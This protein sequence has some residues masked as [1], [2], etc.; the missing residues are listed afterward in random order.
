MNPAFV[1][2]LTQ[3]LGEASPPAR[4]ETVSGGDINAAAIIR[5]ASASYFAKFGGVDREA[6][7]AEAEGLATLRQANTSLV[8]PKPLA[9]G[10]AGGQAFLVLEQLPLTRKSPTTDRALGMG[11]AELHAPAQPR[12]G[13]HR[14][15]RI[16]ATPQPNRWSDDWVVFF[17]RYRLRHQARLLGH[18][19]VSDAVEA[20]A[21]AL[22]RLFAGFE[23]YPSLL[24]GDLWGGNYAGTSDGGA[25]IYDPACYCGCRESDLAMTELFGGFGPAFYQAYEDRLPL[26]AGYRQRRPL[27][28]LYHV[29]NH[30]N[31]FGGSYLG[32][33]LALL[34]KLIAT[35]R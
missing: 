6:F 19:G 23:P 28:Q 12:F 29:L 13:W 32:Q 1:A 20:L 7:E 25:A 21:P 22:H 10:D 33:A 3:A 15:N 4:W 31:L 14:D 27:Y 35:A 24:H 8:I 2:S 26:H 34:E 5:F 17:T 11:L 18:A 9:T 16:G 30:A